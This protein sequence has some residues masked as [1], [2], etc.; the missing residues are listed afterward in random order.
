MQFPNEIV[1]DIT[2]EEI[3]KGVPK[4]AATCPAAR[5]LCRDFPGFE[6]MVT[7]K[8]TN[9]YH[10][11]SCHVVAKYQNDSDLECQIGMFDDGLLFHPGQYKLMKI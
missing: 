8:Q 10:K 9:F 6:V 5:A 4:D 2:K 11:G 1:T 3:E 7:K